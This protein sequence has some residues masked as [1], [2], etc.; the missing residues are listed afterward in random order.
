[1]VDKREKNSNADASHYMRGNVR[2]WN[3]F[4]HCC[5]YERDEN[6]FYVVGEIEMEMV[7]KFVWNFPEGERRVEV[8]HYYIH[9]AVIDAINRKM[10][11]V[12]GSVDCHI[13]CMFRK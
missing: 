10:S 7:E 5:L 6:V 1:M 4:D 11:N 3:C 12:I 13:L 8:L 9:R 2:L